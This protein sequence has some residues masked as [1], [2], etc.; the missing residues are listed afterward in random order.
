[1]QARLNTIATE[2]ALVSA[3]HGFNRVGREIL[4]AA[5][6]VGAQLKPGH[7]TER[8]RNPTHWAVSDVLVNPS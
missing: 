2:G 7:L 4:V 3:D 5:L 6:A 8:D 1:M